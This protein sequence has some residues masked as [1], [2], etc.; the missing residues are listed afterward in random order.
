LTDTIGRILRSDPSAAQGAK[1]E[2]WVSEPF[3]LKKQMTS[4]LAQSDKSNQ[5]KPPFLISRTS[6][7]PFSAFWFD[8][9]DGRTSK[10]GRHEEAPRRVQIEYKVEAFSTFEFL[11][12]SLT[13]Q[14]I[15]DS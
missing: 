5:E 4:G 9:S 10:C 7:R 1:T 13:V 14:F 12:I 11:S 2:A 6:D 3:A 8:S 15:A